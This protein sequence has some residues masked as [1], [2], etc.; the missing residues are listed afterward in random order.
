MKE[1]MYD[2]FTHVGVDYSQQDQ[3]DLYDDQMERF[4]DYDAEA[5]A[6]VETM[7]T[8]HPEALTVVDLGCG[9]GAFSIHAA[10]Y[11]K[12][13][14]AVDVSEAML[15]IAQSKATAKGIHNIEFCHAGFLQFQVSTPVDVVFSKWAF[16]HLPDYWKQAALFNINRMLKMDGVFMLTDLVFRYDPDYE[17]TID[18]MIHDLSKNFDEAFIQETRV[19]IRDEYST[20]DWILRGLIERAGFSLEHVNAEDMLASEYICRKYRSL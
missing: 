10:Q 5:K 1:W 11:L 6:F 19:H 18:A 13:V 17:Q 12:K 9:T 8:P 14:Y 16:H 15:A 20:F 2:E 7:G 3:A 4:R